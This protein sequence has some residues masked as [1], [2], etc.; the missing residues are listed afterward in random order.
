[1][2]Q[3]LRNSAA[4]FLLCGVFGC[5]SPTNTYFT[6]SSTEAPSP[7]TA[8]GSGASPSVAVVDVEIPAYLDRPQIVVKSDQN[9]ADLHEYDRWVEPLAGMI[10][11]TM[12][13][14]L[15]ARLGRDRVLDRPD[16][17][18]YLLSITIDEF[19][20]SEGRVTL[21]GQWTLSRQKEEHAPLPHSFSRSIPLNT[22]EIS[23]SVAAMSRLLGSLADDITTTMASR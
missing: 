23:E 16:A 15:A 14:D 4:G 5:S 7:A 17:A 19:G 10:Q 21:R 8:R 13:A 1:M 12:R 20:P 22:M 11:D 2:N 9:R 18:N 3:I 6:L